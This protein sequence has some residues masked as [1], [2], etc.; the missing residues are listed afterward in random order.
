M[1]MPRKLTLLAALVPLFALVACGGGAQEDSDTAQAAPAAPADTQ[2]PAI[3]LVASAARVTGEGTLVLTATATDNVGVKTIAFY[4]GS[5]LLASAA[6]TASVAIEESDNGTHRYT[7]IAR[8]AAGNST[9]S[10]AVSVDVVIA[11]TLP[12][13]RQTKKSFLSLDG[14]QTVWYWEYLPAGYTG[15]TKTYPLLVFFHGYGENGAAD[16][17]QLDFVKRHGPPKLIGANHD[18]CFETADGRECFVVVSPQNGRGWWDSRDTAGMLAHAMRSYRIDPTRVYVTGL[19]MG[20]GAT[21][22]LASSTEPGTSPAS[23][24][25]GK[26]AAAAPVCGA[27]ESKSFNGGICNGIVGKSLPVWAFHGDA[28]PT[29]SLA[30]SQG[31]VSKINRTTAADGYNCASAASPA[32]KLTVYAGVGHDSWTRTYDPAREVEP[33]KNLYQWLLAQ[34]RL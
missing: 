17:S 26:I 7:A 32:A 18:M 11:T 27:A 19:S 13:Q 10:S 21:W 31:W 16:G 33:G 9:T 24:W 1:P 12:S 3:E 5:T 29:I 14:A 30:T 23:W 4:D 2:A 6:G 25:A 20:G 34:R 15:S 8:D 28:D 22:T